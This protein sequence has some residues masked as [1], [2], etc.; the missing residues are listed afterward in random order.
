MLEFA[1]TSQLPQLPNQQHPTTS[2]HVLPSQYP[3]QPLLWRLTS[4]H[5]KAQGIKPSN[6]LNINSTSALTVGILLA[7]SNS[8]QNKRNSRV[9]ST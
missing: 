1:G 7:T 3:A 6:N 4:A 2:H 5:Y 8:N 9:H